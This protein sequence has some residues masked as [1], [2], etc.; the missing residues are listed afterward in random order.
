MHNVTRARYHARR[1]GVLRSRAGFHTCPHASHLQYVASVTGLLVVSRRLE[2][3]NG[4][5]AGGGMCSRS[6]VSTTLIGTSALG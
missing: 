4:H 5:C 1:A 6:C 2:R 3:Q